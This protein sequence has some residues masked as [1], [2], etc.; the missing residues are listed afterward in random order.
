[1]F[2]PL[3]L[4]PS[5]LGFVSNTPFTLVT[6]TTPTVGGSNDQFGID[7][8]TVGGAVPEPA[9]WAMMILGMGVVGYAMRRKKSRVTAKVR[10]A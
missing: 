8:V 10:F 7:N 4:S 1:M 5:F 9:T 2:N 6:F 3:P